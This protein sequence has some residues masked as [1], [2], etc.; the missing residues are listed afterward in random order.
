MTTALLASVGYPGAGKSV[1]ADAATELDIPVF[2]MGDDVRARVESAY[3]R[4]A[5]ELESATIREWVTEQRDRHGKA[6]V[7]Q[8]TCERIREQNPPVA[9]VDG[10]RSHAELAVFDSLLPREA[11]GS[12]VIHV[13]AP[14]ERRLDRLQTRNRNGEGEFGAADLRARDAGEE[15]WGLTAALAAAEYTFV[16]DGQSLS[17]ARTS[18]RACLER[19]LAEVTH[20]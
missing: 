4:P 2:E 16:N 7:G 9:F 10:A 15:D 17:A 5:S 11:E 6:V 14:F 8:W 13:E 12:T 1:L 20:E 19:V 18:A 3:G